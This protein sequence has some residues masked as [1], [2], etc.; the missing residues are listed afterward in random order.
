MGAKTYDL[1]FKGYWREPNTG[2][3]P[4]KSGVYSVYACTRTGP[5]EIYIRELIYIGESIRVRDRI[6]SHL[7]WEAW[8][9][10]LEQGEEICFSFAPISG[11][12]DRERVEAALINRH[13]P[14]E[15]TKY[16]DAFPYPVTIVKTAGANAELAESFIVL[17]T[18]E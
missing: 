12:S 4:N 3:I 7:K 14:P 5:R 6:K 11:K 16:V 18:I 15:N 1:V 2:G 9:E 8:E 10:Y 17:R 13:T